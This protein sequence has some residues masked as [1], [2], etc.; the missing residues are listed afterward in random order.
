MNY[1]APV[2]EH[3][4]VCGASKNY[5]FGPTFCFMD[6]I[7]RYSNLEQLFLVTKYVLK[8]NILIYFNRVSHFRHSE[9]V[10]YNP[11]FQKTFGTDFHLI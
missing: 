6:D 8:C 9:F 2:V 5:M 7:G 11:R 4:R 10:R 3:N 1:V